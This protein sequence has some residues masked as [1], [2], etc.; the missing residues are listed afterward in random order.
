MKKKIGQFSSRVSEYDKRQRT[1][2]MAHIFF[3]KYCTSYII[4]LLGPKKL[5]TKFFQNKGHR[6]EEKR[7]WPIL[8]KLL[9]IADIE[10]LFVRLHK[11]FWLLCC[12]LKDHV[13]NTQEF[14][15]NKQFRKKEILP[16]ENNLGLFFLVLLSVTNLNEQSVRFHKVFR[17]LQWKF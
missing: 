11:V 15:E 14:V 8:L 2:L 3:D 16:M 1:F 13:Y 4:I 17:Q 12:K 7:F 9:T 6:S 10:Y 5:R